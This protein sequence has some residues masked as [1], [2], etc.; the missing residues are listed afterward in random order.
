MV[1]AETMN[2]PIA[3]ALLVLPSEITN[4]RGAI[5]IGTLA[6]FAKPRRPNEMPGN[7]SLTFVDATEK[8]GRTI[9]LPL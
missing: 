9:S 2:E 7:E 3:K 5:A 1:K 4:A 8:N 6:T